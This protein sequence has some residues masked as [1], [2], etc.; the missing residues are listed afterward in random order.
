MPWEQYQSPKNYTYS[1]GGPASADEQSWPR[2]EISGV[3]PVAEEPAA[4]PW[5]QYAAPLSRTEKFVQG[6]RDPIDGGAQLL[7]NMLPDRIVNAGNT[8][9]NFL[10]DKTGLVGRL[11]EGG[12]DQQVRENDAAYQSQRGDTGFDGYRVMGNMASP[13]N[14]VVAAKLPFAATGLARVGIGA[15][16]GAAN[17]LLSP[18]TNGDYSEEKAWQIGAGAVGGGLLSGI[19]SGISRMISPNA[20]INPE[21]Q[22][23]KAEGVAPTI[24]Q[25]LGGRW[26]ALEE[27]MTSVPILGD[28]I[29]NARTKALQSFNQA[30]INRATAPINQKVGTIGQDGVRDAGDALSAAYN[31]AIAKVSNVTLDS[32]F[33]KSLSQLH[34]MTQGLTDPMRTKFND[35]L[36]NVVMRQVSP[37]GSILGSSYKAMD[38][39]LGNLASRFGKST[40]ASES[41]LGDAVKQLQSLLRA[42]MVRSNPQVAGEIHAADQGWANLVRVEGAA[43]AAKNGD[44]IFTPAQLNMA[45]QSADDSVRKR[46]ISRGT[47]L[48]QDL[49]NAGQNVIGNKIPNSFTTDRALMAGGTLGSYLLNPAIPVGLLGGAAMYSQPV[50]SLLRGAVSAR[51]QAA[52][53]VAEAFKKGSAMFLPL[54][55]Q[56]GLGLLNN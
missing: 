35:A 26:N 19:T 27:K 36:Q 9:N 43:K 22:L 29:A 20:S 4:M 34:D 47:A 33:G 12:V 3:A 18:V 52:Q 53:G 42:Q 21:L 39:E 56:Y 1:E 15:L 2:V 5:T 45:A 50:Q 24:G 7:T 14:F 11:P 30:A 55:A 8:F 16:G 32:Q 23:L 44:G 25:T 46:A 10:A 49:G 37:Q 6:M 38:S 41:E 28:A 31:S 13:A 17:G 40:V 51:P 48:M 54:G